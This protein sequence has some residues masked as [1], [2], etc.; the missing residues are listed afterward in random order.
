M[1]NDDDAQ[2][3]V[4]HP[5][6]SFQ[7]EMINYGEVSI[8]DANDSFT[9]NLVQ[10]FLILGAPVKVFRVREVSVSDVMEQLGDYLVLSPGPGIPDDAGI[11]KEVAQL[12]IGKIPILG[13]CLGMQ[14]INELF[15]GKTVLADYPYHGKISEIVHNG[16]GIFKGIPSPTKVARYHSLMIRN[17]SEQFEVQCVID[18]IVMAFNSK[19]KL[20]SAVQFH[21]ESFLTTHGP[22]ML[23]NYLEGVY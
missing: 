2:Q 17:L 1:L 14:A 21:P 20:I 4:T 22:T 13:V 11:M 19:N 8:L 5:I 7:P 6:E 12:I 9:H 10:A 16:K 15:G 3:S 18:D 23:K